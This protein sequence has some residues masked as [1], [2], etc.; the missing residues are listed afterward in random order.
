[1]IHELLTHA[2]E[3]LNDLAHIGDLAYLFKYDSVHGLFP[4]NMS[5]DERSA[6]RGFGE[7]FGARGFHTLTG[8]DLSWDTPLP[9]ARHVIM[10]MDEPLLSTLQL[11]FPLIIVMVGGGI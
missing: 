7:I 9:H 10:F 4:G 1:M 2:S 3:S 6:T 11:T 5:H 8:V